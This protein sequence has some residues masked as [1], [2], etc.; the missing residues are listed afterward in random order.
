MERT[1]VLALLMVL[2]LPSES[3]ASISDSITLRSIVSPAI[4]LDKSLPVGTI[5]GTAGVSSSGAATYTIPINVAS[6]D[7]G[8]AP[9]LQ[10][11]YNSQAGDGVLG[12]GWSLTS[13][14][15]ISRCRKTI[16][17]D[18]KAEEIKNDADDN[19]SLDGRRLLLISG[20]NLTNG[21]VYNFEDDPSTK[22]V[23]NSLN[24]YCGFTVYLKD[25]SKREYGL[26]DNSYISTSGVVWLWLLN[27]STDIR[28]RTIEYQYTISPSTNE[29]VLTRIKYDVYRF[30]HFTY[31]TRPHSYTT[32]FAGHK[33][34]HTK[35]L[36]K[37]SCYKQGERINEYR[38]TYSQ[39][40][41]YSKITDITYY[42]TDDSHYNPIHITYGG[43]SYRQERI[44]N[45]SEGK[46]GDRIH[47]GDLDG[48]GKTDFI[49]A[50]VFNPSWDHFS[51]YEY[52]SIYLAKTIN[53]ALCFEKTDSIQLGGVYGLWLQD[54]DGDGKSEIV[55]AS[56]HVSP[57]YV[58]HKYYAVT[59]GRAYCK[60]SF[61][62]EGLGGDFGGDFNGDGKIE[63]MNFRNKK[64][65]NLN[66]QY[67]LTA[68]DINWSD[69]Y[70]KKSYI[71]STKFATD[72][73]G[74]GKEDIIVIGDNNFHVYELSNGA[75]GEITSFANNNITRNHGISCCDL[76]GDGYTDVI[77]QRIISSNNIET[78]IYL[79]T[80]RTLELVS[81]LT[82]KGI[83]RTGDFNNDGKSD[84][85]CLYVEGDTVKYTVGISYGTYL[86]KR[87]YTTNV[88]ASSDLVGPVWVECFFSVADFDGD[89]R[90]EI[91]FFRGTNS[92][93]IIDVEDDSNLIVSNVTNG[94]GKIVT[95]NY[96]SSSESSICQIDSEY[97]YPLSGF[98]RCVNLVTS[99]ETTDQDDNFRIDYTYKSP[100]VNNLGKG[101]IGFQEIVVTDEAAELIT[102]TDYD[103]NSE[104][105]YPYIA[106]KVVNTY[107]N[108]TV[109]IDH[110]FHHCSPRESIHSKAFVPYYN[111]HYSFDY[112]RY[113]GVIKSL[114]IDYYGNPVHDFTYYDEGF[115]ETVT[116]TYNNV[117]SGDWIIGQPTSVTKERTANGDVFTDKQVVTYNVQHLP[118]KIL[119]YTG[120][121]TKLVSEEAF[122]YDTFGNMTSHSVKP[123]A[124]QNA[125]T[126]TYQYT[127]D[128]TCLSKTTDPLSLSTSY[129]Y[130]GRCRLK[131]I[132]ESTGCNTTYT[133][134]GLSRVIQEMTGDTAS[135]STSWNW[136]QDS[137]MPLYCKSVAGNDGSMQKTWYDA[138]GRELRNSSLRF[139][140][141]E[142]ITDKQYDSHGWLC[143]V[144]LPYKNGGPAMWSNI[145]YDDYGRV[146]EERHASGRSV[147]YLYNGDTTTIIEDSI[148]IVKTYNPRK[149]LIKVSDPSGDV[150][151]AIRADGQF[152]SVKA[153]E[154]TTYFGY[155]QYGRQVSISDPSAGMHT[156]N[157]RSDGLLDSETDANGRTIAY[158]Y[159]NY[160][161]LGQ[162]IRPEMTS[163][164]SYDS[165]NR[166]S[167]LLSDNGTGEQY[168]YDSFGRLS[169]RRSLMPDG[170]YIQ[171]EY[172]YGLGNVIAIKYSNQSK[173]LGT[174]RF[175]YS[176]GILSHITFNGSEVR[177][178]LSEN[179]QGKLT[180]DISGPLAFSC[181]YDNYGMINNKKILA[182][183]STLQDVSYSYSVNT[184][185]L[186]WKTDNLHDKTDCFRYDNLNRLVSYGNNSIT[187]DEK[188]NIL[189]KS[190]ASL[191][192]GYNHPTKPYAVTDIAEGFSPS[193][194]RYSKQ[195]IAYNSFESPDTI[196]D[197]DRSVT[198]VY[199]ADGHRVMMKGNK[200]DMPHRYYTDNYYEEDISNGSASYCLYLG[201]DA[202]SAPA[203]FVSSD[204]ASAIYYIGRDRQ[205]SITHIV[206]SNGVLLQE[207]S[208][209][210]W[211]RLQDPVTHVIYPV[212]EEPLLS[213]GRGYCG[214]EHLQHFGLINMNARLYDP[215]LGRF[216]SPDPYVQAPDNSQNFN[217]YSYCLNNPLKYTDPSGEFIGT[218]FAAVTD[219]VGN[220][221]KHGLNIRTYNWSKTRNAWQIDLAP[222]RGG[223]ID[224]LGNLTWGV[225]NTL[226]GNITGHSTNFLGMVDGVSNMEGLTAVGGVTRGGSAFTVGPYSFGPKNYKAS[227]KD[228]TFVHEY[229]HYIQHKY[230]GPYYLSTIAVPS[231]L[232]ASGFFSIIK[233]NNRWFEVD[234]SRRGG[235]YF[236][237]KYGR[238]KDGYVKGSVD[239]FDI[240]SFSTDKLSPYINPRTGN[241]NYVR[242]P[243]NSPKYTFWD[244]YYPS[245]IFNWIPTLFI[246]NI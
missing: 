218:I 3:F 151:Y 123:Y 136:N 25:G 75:I 161:R 56:V 237:K 165:L 146:V 209:D 140:G 31:A 12:G 135:I 149:E 147:R 100:L 4:P 77:S 44:V 94:L 112:K 68:P 174:E 120:D 117:V 142:L 154:V 11:V 193:D 58:H 43:E 131:K 52:A 158:I 9:S 72:F 17:Y 229:G 20:D 245:I 38:L 240:N 48:D 186:T 215:V 162:M 60:Y 212:D 244:Y 71:P 145:I 175:E 66:G 183:G 156:F 79:S 197:N 102:S 208:Y 8:Y 108:D 84:V 95:F 231:L 203:V 69:H 227:W 148:S 74:N 49:T 35:R 13:V 40:G 26:V 15:F 19:L 205:G 194:V 55:T 90:S 152:S 87:T 126:T 236:D 73:N 88:L 41:Q 57:N 62:V 51:I 67:L 119:T 196:T 153:H 246:M 130:D 143:R 222:F 233:H 81:S 45:Y 70:D 217:R 198:F 206:D 182:N 173:I 76:N 36:E 89:G 113:F 137:S 221:F 33:I 30:V 202:Y 201:G 191:S 59:N 238:G 243:I 92:A 234:A 232:S 160:G 42:G 23:Y 101:F 121:G 28:G 170:K 189:T 124:S 5:E 78:N 106:K 188:G 157:Y 39:D 127:S 29:F 122:V 82:L 220:V 64:V 226:I 104:Y 178:L 7:F 180:L 216:L 200:A 98:G 21:A 224:V 18:G 192:L 177:Q 96:Q 211:G 199:N 235:E 107:S 103:Y 118:D 97:I 32:Y 10:L 187:Y 190:D 176:N 63:V 54:V 1:H 225:S 80:G 134:D 169:C 37:L 128:H 185:N 179:S 223:L 213:L 61:D 99:I 2:L 241:R 111:A 166:L 219:F 242:Y 86:D 163:T 50:P 195:N 228:H 91:G 184:G 210:P 132:I 46:N 116:T 159:D 133:Y 167:S 141:S 34:I 114:Q 110:F 22:I 115:M 230:L 204:S 53:G 109:S 16:Y 144:S 155:D 239:Y 105:Y 125:L 138:F 93:V 207:Y 172:V 171:Q 27:K 6:G 164:Y 14:S 85:A 214:H 139:D 83:I 65:Y 181:S 24:S 129:Q 47:Y 150:E 168:F